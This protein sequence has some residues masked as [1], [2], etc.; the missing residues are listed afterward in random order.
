ML[1][2]DG[3]LINPEVRIENC[4]KCNGNCTICPR[5]KLTRPKMEM[6]F[7]NFIDLVDQAKELGA[8]TISIFGFGEPYL[9][10]ALEDKISYCRL[11]GLETFIT[12][13]GSLV[14]VI[15]ARKSI[16]AGLNHIRFS[17]HSPE[18][19]GSK[20]YEEAIRNVGNFIALNKIRFHKA[21]K[22]SIT[23]IP[24]KNEGLDLVINTWEPV[25]DY[26]EIW[27]PHNWTDGR[28]YRRID[29]KK[30]TCNRPFN[31]PV[32]INSNGTVMV[33]CFDY[34]GKLTI[35]DTRKKS[36]KDILE[37]KELAEIRRKHAEGNLE[38]LICN[39]CDQLNE[40]RDN[41]LLYSSRDPER[42]LNTTSSIKYSLGG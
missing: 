20:I 34:D 19:Q 7:E 29:R 11:M 36:L 9:D 23:M 10:K 35:G 39:Q 26:L 31:G 22:I 21:C 3:K 1:D 28:T 2:K 18:V 5:E 38:G 16:L 14:D 13:N 33:C 25:V 15:R 40:E 8:K 32:Q 24:I 17:V 42:K 27:E 12:T 4:S 37:G 41:P 6:F 30:Q